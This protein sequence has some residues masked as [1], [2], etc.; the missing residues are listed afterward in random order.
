MQVTVLD[1]TAS[2]AASYNQL[3]EVVGNNLLLGDWCARRHWRCVSLWIWHEERL[4][5]TPHAAVHEMRC[6]VQGR[7]GPPREP[8]GGRQLQVGTRDAHQCAVSVLSFLVHHPHSLH[9]AVFKSRPEE[10]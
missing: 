3:I 6:P 8:A 7:R 4:M 9:A 10:V 1:F 5:C 2:H